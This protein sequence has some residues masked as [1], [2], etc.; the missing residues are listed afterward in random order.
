MPPSLQLKTRG[1]DKERGGLSQREC[2]FLKSG[3]QDL[4]D[5]GGDW[6]RVCLGGLRKMRLGKKWA[7]NSI[8]DSRLFNKQDRIKEK[9][10]IFICYC[11]DI[12]PAALNFCLTLWANV[13]FIGPCWSWE[14]ANKDGN[15]NER[16]S[17]C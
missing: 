16:G 8:P 6:T 15:T 4:R 7:L 13:D 3:D 5:S 10:P 14:T 2:P 17:S 12:V 9:F 1:L 11:K